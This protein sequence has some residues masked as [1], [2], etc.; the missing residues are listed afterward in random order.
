[1]PDEPGGGTEPVQNK[2]SGE[3]GNPDGNLL[4]VRV[5]HQDTDPPFGMNFRNFRGSFHKNLQNPGGCGGRA[6]FGQKTVIQ[7]VVRVRKIPGFL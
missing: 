3:I 7:V 5:I 4:R 2:G 6:G 1:M